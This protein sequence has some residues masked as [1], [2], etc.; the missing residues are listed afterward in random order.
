M[1]SVY[2]S[3]PRPEITKS[4]FKRLSELNAAPGNEIQH[5]YVYEYMPRRVTASV[6]EGAAAFTA[7][8]AL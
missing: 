6:P 5:G 4:L 3:G 7:L 2:Q 1:K 8:L